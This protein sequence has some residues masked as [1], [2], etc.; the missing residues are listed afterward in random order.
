MKKSLL[1]LVLLFSLNILAAEKQLVFLNQH[2]GT[3][4]R[5]IFDLWLPATRKE[6]PLVIYIHGGGFVMGSKDEI[7]NSNMYLVKKY[8]KEGIAFAAINYRYLSH[9]SLQDIMREDIAGFVQYMRLNAKKYNLDKKI[10]M[11][12]GFSA[13]GSSSLWLATHNDIALKKSDN[14]LKLESSRVFAAGHLNAQV[15]YDYTVWY[16]YFGKENTDKFI[17]SQVWTRYR[18]NS[19]EDIYTE[20]G[21]KIREDL[22]M[23]GNMTTDDCPILFANDLNDNETRDGNHFVHSPRHTRLLSEKAKSLGLETVVRIKADGTGTLDPHG[24]VFDFFLQRL[25]NKKKDRKSLKKRL[26]LQSK[27]TQV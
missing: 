23:Y 16:K 20:A 24:A 17:G 3:H 10:I 5:Q 9:A 21:Q 18:L 7:S 6:A 12:Y 22:D 8:N 27:A 13:G 26:K 25:I 1:L 15:S 11:P 14:P 2:Y 4:E 19:Y